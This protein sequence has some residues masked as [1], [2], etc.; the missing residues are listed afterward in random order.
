MKFSRFYLGCVND[1]LKP[2]W[3]WAKI[4][5]ILFYIFLVTLPLGRRKILAQLTNGFDEYETIFLYISDILLVFFLLVSFREIWQFIVAR[6]KEV[7]FFSLLIFFFASIISVGLAA[8]PWLALINLLR[9]TLLIL[10]AFGVGAGIRSGWINVRAVFLI[11]IFL[12]VFEA[13]LGFSQFALQKNIGL[14]FMGEPYLP[15]LVTSIAPAGVPAGIAKIDLYGGKLIRAYGTFPHP[16]ILAAFL[17]LSL[18]SLFYF[19]VRNTFKWRG[20]FYAGV[21]RKM[22]KEFWIYAAREL[23]L[24]IGIF[25]VSLGLLFT[26]SRAAWLVAMG[27]FIAF[28]IFTF[29][30]RESRRQA[31]KLFFLCLAVGYILSVNFGVLMASR[32]HISLKEPAVTYRFRYNEVAFEIIKNHPL[33]IGIGNQVIY[34][35][36]N[37]L[38]QKFDMRAL[39]AWQPVHN[40]YLLMASEIGVLGLLAFLSFVF[41]LVF[42]VLRN[43]SLEAIT[44][45]SLLGVLLLLGLTD[46]FLWTLQPGRIMLWLV[47]GFVLGLNKKTNP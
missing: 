39:W 36:K 15:R 5:G 16:N 17:L 32:A 41:I 1:V 33:G 11:L 25:M 44:A 6:K 4:K 47:I 26:F 46:H 38:Y 2:S 18:T 10:M 29:L 3:H 30:K 19:W 12:G 35:V 22:S 31:V 27:L 37:Q 7:W 45:L 14:S 28:S 42:Q 9:L 43:F 20:F 21:G 23:L 40:I 13:V 34:S 24:G 8:L